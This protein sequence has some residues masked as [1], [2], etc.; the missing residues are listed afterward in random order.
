MCGLEYH[1]GGLYINPNVTCVTPVNIAY[2]GRNLGPV[3]CH[4][5]GDVDKESIPNVRKLEC[6]YTSVRPSCGSDECPENLLGKQ[7][8]KPLNP[9][10]RQ[11]AVKRKKKSIVHKVTKHRKGNNGSR[12]VVSYSRKTLDNNEW[13]ELFRNEYQDW[14]FSLKTNWKK[15]RKNRKLM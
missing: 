15:S 4:Y 10:K 12:V 14:I 8:A 3:C 11:A 6:K 9:K 5:C 13:C 7:R 1:K 2:Y